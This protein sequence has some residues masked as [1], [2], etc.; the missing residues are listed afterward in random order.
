MRILLQSLVFIISLLVSIS[1]AHA[2]CDVIDVIEMYDDEDM[3]KREIREECGKSVSDAP[4]CSI[5]KIIR[6]S[7]DGYD[8][9]EI[10]EKCSGS[11][12]TQTGKG[13]GG[14][15]Q[16]PDQRSQASN[17]CQT[18]MMWCALGQSGPVGTPCW[19]QTGYGPQN[20]QIAPR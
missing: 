15:Q 12:G 11:R 2:N 4:N 1:N 14:R 19:C 7:D 17:I 16:Q 18:A 6:F 8:E 5:R 9:D 13:Y 3:S 20:G 10:V